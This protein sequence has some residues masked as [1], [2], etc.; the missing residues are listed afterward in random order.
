MGEGR[1]REGD[2]ESEAG[3]R[4]RAV[5]TEPDMGLGPWTMRYDL[6]QSQTFNRMSHPGA[7]RET[8]FKKAHDLKKTNGWTHRCKWYYCDFLC[9]TFHCN[10]LNRMQV[11]LQKISLIH[12]VSPL[13]SILA[14]SR[15]S[16]IYLVMMN[17]WIKI[18]KECYECREI[19][20]YDRVS[21]QTFGRGNE[22]YTRT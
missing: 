15:Y 20:L 7:P 14:H 12:A 1:E 13:P 3:S 10:I 5:S 2:T 8:T 19:D 6:S 16:R 21:D 18:S 9:N 11:S 4:V 22:D 17:K